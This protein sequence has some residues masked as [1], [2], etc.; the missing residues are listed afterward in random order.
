M[1]FSSLSDMEDPKEVEKS[2]LFS[3]TSKSPEI[4][5]NLISKFIPQREVIS[6][7]GTLLPHLCIISF[8]SK[9]L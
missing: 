8:N 6:L 7:V 2:I 4:S 9:R 3:E 5:E 1:K